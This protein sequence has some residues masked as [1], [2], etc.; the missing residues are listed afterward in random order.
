MGINVRNYYVANAFLVRH[1]QKYLGY[2]SQQ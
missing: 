1:R 2:I